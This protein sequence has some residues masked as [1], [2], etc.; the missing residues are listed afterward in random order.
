MNAIMVVQYRLP[1][2][3]YPPVFVYDVKQ[4]NGTGMK[5]A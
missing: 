2:M 3:R 5:P 4:G 1:F